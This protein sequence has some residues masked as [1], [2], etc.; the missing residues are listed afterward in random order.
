MSLRLR[1]LEIRVITELGP[2]GTR[3]LFQEGLVVLRGD[4]SSGKS[5]CL[6]AILYALGLEGLFIRSQ[7]SPFP[8]A[9]TQRLKAGD[10]WVSVVE[11]SVMLE[12]A[13]P[14]GNVITTKRAVTG[15]NDARQLI[16][17]LFGAAVTG[18]DVASLERRDYFVR[19]PVPQSE[20]GFHFYLA[21][22]LAFELPLVPRFDGVPV[23]SIWNRCFRLCLLTNFVDGLV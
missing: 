23:P 3:L 21:K 7:D 6:A 20:S 9:M 10:N 15:S 19:V 11:S 12:F 22:L 13:G 16:T 14:D 1:A 5:T 4:N 2:Y 8:E 18:S 17:V